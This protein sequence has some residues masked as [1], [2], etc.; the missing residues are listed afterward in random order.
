MV[1]ASPDF[2]KIPEKLPPD[3]DSAIQNKMNIRDSVNFMLPILFWQA[4]LLR[5]PRIP[6]ERKEKTPLPEGNEV[7]SGDL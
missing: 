5:K 4:I 7:F 1:V 3:P 6:A 2:A